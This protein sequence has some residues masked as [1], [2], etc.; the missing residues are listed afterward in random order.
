MAGEST[1]VVLNLHKH[2]TTGLLTIG[3]LASLA[4]TL[5]A[6]DF[7]Y[8]LGTS[9]GGVINPFGTVDLNSGAFTVIGSMGSGGYSGLA[10]ANG[11]VYTEQNG[12]LY[13]VNTSNANLTLI[14]GLTGNNMATFGSTTTGL[15][16]L[17]ST[18]SQ[19]VATLFSINPATGGITAIG[20]VGV[21]GNGQGAYARLS[22][23]SST[24][25]MENA[26]NLYTLNTT[27]GAGTQVGTTDGNGYLTSVLLLENGTYY[28]GT[29][30]G[31]GTIN[32]TTGQ[33]TPHSSIF[34][35]GNS[36]VVGL[37]PSSSSSYYFSQLAVGGG[38]QTTLTYVNYSPQPVT[39]MT[40][41]YSDQGTP[42]A[43]PFNQGTISTRTDVLPPGGSIH[44]QSVA[45]LSAAVSQGWAQA[46]CTGPLAAS[47]L[48]RLYQSGVATGE[49]SVSAE[50]APTTE[51]ATF[52]QTA[53]GIAYANPS[54]TQSAAITV[55][56]YNASGTKQGS[57]VINLGPMAH[58]SAN[59]GPL[60]GLTS[61]TGFVKITSTIPI[62]SLSLNA[63]A[64]PVFS[65]LP[66]GD[67]PS[68]TTLAP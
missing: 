35:I 5:E 37:A 49:A 52:A 61:F 15:Y 33:I 56:V 68:S 21:I 28:A 47:V 17:A 23:G 22:V 54:T 39:C 44:D 26:S 16:G 42:L 64:Y 31:F 6:D 24:L 50:T 45:S 7:A 27:T 46:A 38:W 55:T 58:G 32:I 1:E 51:F 8:M 25:Y 53:T 40:S 29:G 41:F 10:V 12:L 19:S 48:Y 34:G 36:S 14:G 20:P 65:S 60:L 18:G 57:Q 2:M 4:S 63:E 30:A 9:A 43:I 3:L 11:V 62:I 66:P 59:V 67:L 13:S